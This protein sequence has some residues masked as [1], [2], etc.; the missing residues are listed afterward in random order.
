[1]F[2]SFEGPEGGGK[3]TQI[4]RLAAALHA[5]GRVVRVVREPGSTWL[6]EKIR[7]ALLDV[8]ESGSARMSDRAEALLF[9]AARAQLVDEVI[10]PAL[11]HGEIVLAD[12]FSDSTRAYQIAGRGL[13]SVALG[14]VID[15]A[16]GGLQPDLTFLLDLDAATGL[17][18]KDRRGDRME[19]EGIEFHRRV[20][21]GFLDLARQQPTR[22][23]VLE[24]TRGPDEIAALIRAQL[25][26]RLGVGSLKPAA[27]TS[28]RPEQEPS[29]KEGE[30]A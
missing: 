22:I 5:E 4:E 2:V 10:R 28:P 19:R 30:S 16:T 17:A 23:V 7:Q 26:D 13:S 25:A 15:F 18:R 12:R 1:M 24:A 9:A 3:T 6:G 20:R 21:A 27:T 11:D 14:K 29:P 8:P